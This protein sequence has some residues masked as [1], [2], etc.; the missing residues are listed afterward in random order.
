MTTIRAAGAYIDRATS[1]HTYDPLGAQQPLGAGTVQVLASNATRLARENGLRHLWECAGTDD[2]RGYLTGTTPDTFTWDDDP[3]A[4]GAVWYAGA[5]AVRLY[6][7]TSTW[8]KL[9]LAARL[10]A[11][12]PHTAGIILC[13]RTGPGRPVYSDTYATATTSSTS[14]TDVAAT[15]DLA[16]YMT[17]ADPFA[18]RV[19]SASPAVT[20]A[21]PGRESVVHV[22]VG[23]YRD[24]G[25]GAWKATV[26]GL[27]LYLLEP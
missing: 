12:S 8:P 21:E 22:W 15:V 25:A 10:A 17:V 20:V 6:G 23:V 27:S 3:G 13:V 11:P 5:H 18:D 19:G 1:G 2:V 24:G 26:A 9:R 7:E 14:M 16:A 4:G